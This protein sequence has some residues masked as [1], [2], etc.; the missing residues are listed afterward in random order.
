M[1]KFWTISASWYALQVLSQDRPIQGC[2]TSPIGLISGILSRDD[3]SRSGHVLDHF[4]PRLSVGGHI[5]FDDYGMFP[6]VQ[7]TVD[8]YFY[9]NKSKIYLDRVDSTVVHGI[10]V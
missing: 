3:V 2:T 1:W 4:Y 9:H 6:S 8:H 7:H 5:I 10:K